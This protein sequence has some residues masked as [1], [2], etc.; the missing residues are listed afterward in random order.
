[1]KAP[2]VREKSSSWE[3]KHIEKERNNRERDR[4]FLAKRRRRRRQC[5]ER[6]RNSERNRDRV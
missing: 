3:E 2:L 6:G 4:E 1:M 5:T